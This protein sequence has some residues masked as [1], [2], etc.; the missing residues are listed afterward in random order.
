MKNFSVACLRDWFFLIH[1]KLL[2][3]ENFSSS[4]YQFEIINDKNIRHLIHTFLAPA[5]VLCCIC[6]YLQSCERKKV[7][8]D[9]QEYLQKWVELSLF[10]SLSLSGTFGVLC[11]AQLRRC[12]AECL[13]K[14]GAF[15]LEVVA[16]L[17][18]CL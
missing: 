1:C 8:R 16:I 13:P 14:T 17:H 7:A 4:H 15:L 10:M 5:F 11:P 6:T 3:I 12:A 2:F 18:F 9:I